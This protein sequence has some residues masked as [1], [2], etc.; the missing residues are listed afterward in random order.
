MV[1]EKEPEINVNQIS[2][3]VI[4]VLVGLARGVIGF[5]VGSVVLREL[6]VENEN[7]GREIVY[8]FAGSLETTLGRNGAFATLRQ[9]GR[10]LAEKLM[11]DN[12]EAEWESLFHNAL[13]EFGFAQQIKQEKD[14]AF[15]CNCVF[16]DVLKA[17]G[18]GPIEHPV[19]WTGWGFIEGFMKVFE[20]VQRIKWTGRDI[21]AKRCK[22]DFIKNNEDINF[23]K[24]N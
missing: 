1:F 15:I 8:N 2:E 23:N 5:N 10:D 14:S 13:R 7:D 19:C 24:I 3:E 20:G 6:K 16:Y 4:E 11:D 9:V 21:E 17:D 22:F 18:L 12:H